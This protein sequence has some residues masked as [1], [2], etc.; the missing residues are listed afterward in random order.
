ME[1]IWKVVEATNNLYEVSN[2]GNVKREGSL[3]PLEV[4]ESGYV[5]VGI[6]FIYGTFRVWLHR[7]VAVHF[8]EKPEGKDFVNHIDGEK[9]NNKA[10]NLEWV[11]NSENQRH[12]IDILGKGCK[13][14]NNPMYGVKG[15]K[16]PVYKGLIYQIDPSTNEVIASYEGTG[17]LPKEFTTSGVCNVINGRSKT[18]KGY[19]WTRDIGGFKTR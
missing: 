9:Q 15:K 18:H 4:M 16:S 19:I 5:K 6:T 7:L 10:S 2:L 12:R 13:G 14:E 17:D 3:I 11:T 8:C 1:E